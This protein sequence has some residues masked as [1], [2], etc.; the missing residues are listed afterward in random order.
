MSKDIPPTEPTSVETELCDDD[1]LSKHFDRKA[2]HNA[3]LMAKGSATQA[4]AIL[5]QAG[6]THTLQWFY[7]QLKSD[8]ILKA[9][10]VDGKGGYSDHEAPASTTPVQARAI[11]QQLVESDAEFLKQHGADKVFGDDADLMLSF[12]DFA[13]RE[14]QTTVNITYGIS[15][16]SA[17]NLHLRAQEIHKGILLNED[18][19][20]AYEETEDGK[21]VEVSRPKYSEADKLEW[22]KEYTSIMDTLVK[23]SNS[24][25]AAANAKI[26]A[27]KAMSP[28][29]NKGDAKSARG[30][31]NFT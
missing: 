13:S 22:Q 19:V 16:V 10:W 30:K 31:R 27:F 21:L 5:K 24:A 20:T 6:L 4:H 17:K 8:R 3:M 12:A 7:R 18:T 14:F 23:F 26:A 25:T 15:V 9:V 28:G 29:N 2:I 1:N 11:E